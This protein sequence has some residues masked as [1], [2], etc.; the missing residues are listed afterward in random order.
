MENRLQVIGRRCEIRPSLCIFLDRAHRSQDPLHHLIEQCRDPRL[1]QVARTPSEGDQGLSIGKLLRS[2]QAQRQGV[3]WLIGRGCND[4]VSRRQANI[5]FRIAINNGE[6]FQV[7]IAVFHRA[8][9]CQQGLQTQEP[10]CRVRKKWR[11][12]GAIFNIQK[13]LIRTCDAYPLKR[14]SD[15]VV[16]LAQ[17]MQPHRFVQSETPYA[18]H[19]YLPFDSLHAHACVCSGCKSRQP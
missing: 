3:P 11:H 12:E 14:R 6:I 8:G 16:L 17:R 19:Q 10:A 7:R 9:Y 1:L 5:A 18:R 2:A 15:Q 4:V 13:C